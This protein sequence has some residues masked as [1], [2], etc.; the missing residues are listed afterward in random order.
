[1]NPVQRTLSPPLAT[2]EGRAGVQVE[3]YD[4]TK[5]YAYSNIFQVM[6]RVVARFPGEEEPYERVLARI[7]IHDFD[8][9]RVKADML[10]NFEASSLPYLVRPD[11]SRRLADHRERE[12]RKILFFP[13]A[14]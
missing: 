7:G 11:F 8:V 4:E 9:E 12:S 3:V 5:P 10:A 2:F 14:Q 6:L 13:G 1:M